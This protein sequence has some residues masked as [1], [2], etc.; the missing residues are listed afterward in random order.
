MHSEGC[1]PHFANLP[2]GAFQEAGVSLFA[3][4]LI[5]WL[6]LDIRALHWMRLLVHLAARFGT[7]FG[8][9]CRL[10]VCMNNANIIAD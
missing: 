1:A 10:A 7:S 6:T 8:P 9:H 3:N 5:A 4:P 2:I